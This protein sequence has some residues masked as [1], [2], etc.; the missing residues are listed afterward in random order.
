MSSDLNAKK[1]QMKFTQINAG[2][3][4]SRTGARQSVHTCPPGA[5]SIVALRASPYRIHL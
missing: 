4:R 1:K 2:S 5:A 3:W